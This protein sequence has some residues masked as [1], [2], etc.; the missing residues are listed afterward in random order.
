MEELARLVETVDVEVVGVATQKLAHPLAGTYVGKGKLEEIKERRDTVE[1]DLVVVDDELSPAQQRNLEKALDVKIVDRT[2]LILDVFARRAATHEGRLQ[3]ELAQLEYRLPRL[4][5]MWTHLSRQGVGGVGLRGPGETQLE[6]DRRE[7]G[8]RI[9]QIKRELSE[10][11]THR[12]LYRER[13]KGTPIPVVA[14]VGYTNAGKSTL[15]NALTGANVMAEDKLFATLDPTT[16]RATLPGGREV[17]ITD[18]VGF[19][20]N[21]PTFLIAAFRATLEEINEATTLLHVVDVTHPNVAEQMQTVAK[22]LEELGA[23]DKSVVTA[24][25]KVDKL[26]GDGAEV[27][28]TAMLLGQ[29]GDAAALALDPVGISAQTGVGLDRLLARV[30]AALEEDADFVP[31]RLRIPFSRSDLVDRFHR[32]GRVEETEFDEAGTTIL[33]RL[34]AAE[35]GRFEPYLSVLQEAAPAP[36]L[37]EQPV[38]HPVAASV[39]PESAA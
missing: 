9:V 38:A 27:P 12:Q 22:V 11:H 17:L 13:R 35:I 21:L 33:G 30:E 32:A 2:A 6:S 29:L 8:K 28:E 20:N 19:I 5:G 10:V 23:D 39:A 37:V 1:Y 18:T 14:L 36:L 4:T 34:P 25:N 15:L 31:V 24:L 26:A 16:R 7:L 3:V